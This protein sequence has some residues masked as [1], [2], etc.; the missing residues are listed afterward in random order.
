MEAATAP[1]TLFAGEFACA[2]QRGEARCLALHVRCCAVP[3]W[4][5]AALEV[6]N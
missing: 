3:S 5:A 1:A 2:G 4:V 6:L